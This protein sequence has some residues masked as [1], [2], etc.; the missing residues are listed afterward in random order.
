MNEGAALGAAFHGIE[1]GDAERDRTGCCFAVY[2]RAVYGPVGGPLPAVG[3]CSL[4]WGRLSALFGGGLAVRALLGP[5]WAVAAG[6]LVFSGPP[7]FFPET[8]CWITSTIC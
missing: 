2:R 8:A 1:K 6:A 4:L 3:H 7:C 5:T